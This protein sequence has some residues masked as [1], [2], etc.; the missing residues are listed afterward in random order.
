MEQSILES[1]KKKNYFM[2]KYLVKLEVLVRGLVII[3]ILRMFSIS[4]VLVY[5]I[6]NMEGFCIEDYLRFFKLLSI[7][8]K[9]E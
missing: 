8:V 3:R 2:K 7:L 1:C 4:I 9:S 5:Q 6:D